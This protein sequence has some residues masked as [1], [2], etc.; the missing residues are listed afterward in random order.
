M[1]SPESHKEEFHTHPQGTPENHKHSITPY[2]SPVCSSEI[3]TEDKASFT[4]CWFSSSQVCT[5][6]AAN[7]FEWVAV[8]M[9]NAGEKG[10]CT[11]SKIAA[12]GKRHAAMQLQA[13]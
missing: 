4:I 2:T 6:T 9:D 1:Y 8:L 11:Y 5:G 3:Y 10:P 12:T 13:W 7:S